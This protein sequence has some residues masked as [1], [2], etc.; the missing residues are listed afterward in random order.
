MENK[1]IVHTGINNS[2]S[3][4]SKT[5]IT[6]FLLV[7][8]IYHAH[9]RQAYMLFD[10]ILNLICVLVYYRLVESYGVAITL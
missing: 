5:K 1:H 10:G 7:V 3:V 9:K 4:S 6:F 8:Y 2:L